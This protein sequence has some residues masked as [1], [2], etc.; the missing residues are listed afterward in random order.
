[1]FFNIIEGGFKDVKND[2]E[3]GAKT[4]AVAL[5]VKTDFKSFYSYKIKKNKSLREENYEIYR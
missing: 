5:G 1:L 4:T 2:R 3:S